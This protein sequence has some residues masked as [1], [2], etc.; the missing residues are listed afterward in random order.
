MN[1]TS[2]IAVKFG[3]KN[4]YVWLIIVREQYRLLKKNDIKELQKQE[5]NLLTW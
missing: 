2:S 3:Y 1:C 5:S 4:Q